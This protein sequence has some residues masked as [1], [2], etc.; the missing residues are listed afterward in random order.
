M[1][2]PRV[3][4]V[5]DKIHASEM[6]DLLKTL[7]RHGKFVVKV[8]SGEIEIDGRNI[9]IKKDFNFKSSNDVEEKDEKEDTEGGLGNSSL[10][11]VDED[12]VDEDGV[13]EDGVPDVED[14]KEDTE[15][16]SES[17]SLEEFDEDDVP[18]L[19]KQQIQELIS[20]KK[21]KLHMF[22]CE[23]CKEE[24][25]IENNWK[26]DCWY[27]P[28][29]KDV[30]DESDFWDDHDEQSHGDPSLREDDPDF[31]D[32]FIWDCCEGSGSATGCKNTRHKVTEEGSGSKRARY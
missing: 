4:A 28:G 24:F 15:E 12:G 20:S 16:G 22:K 30:D 14:E 21:R 27:H 18:A 25:D 17:D 23:H 7:C 13:D 32:G 8:S 3:E 9:I 2:D 6:R 31:A 1:G 26:R 10:D 11:G 19:S 29:E 5:L